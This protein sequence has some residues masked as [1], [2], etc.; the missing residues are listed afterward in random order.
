MTPINAVVEVP[1]Q[2][3]PEG[4]RTI[5]GVTYIGSHDRATRELGW[6]PRDLRTGLTETLAHELRL[7]GRT[8]PAPKPR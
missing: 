5:A 4:L 2:L 8:L 6:T 1:P 7:L 3:T